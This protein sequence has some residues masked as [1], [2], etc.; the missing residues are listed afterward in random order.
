MT[1]DKNSQFADDETIALMVERDIASGVKRLVPDLARYVNYRVSCI[2]AKSDTW[3]HKESQNVYRVV[4][5]G[6]AA[7]GNGS[8]ALMI[9]YMPETDQHLAIGDMGIMFERQ[10]PFFLERFEPVNPR[11]VWER[12]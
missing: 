9:H 12:A 1:D 2:L 5:A 6:L 10:Y 3:R 4:G 8:L 11:T 7:T